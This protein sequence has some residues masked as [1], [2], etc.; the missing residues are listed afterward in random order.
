VRELDGVTN[1]TT[2]G[3][4]VTVACDPDAKTAVIGALEDAGIT[5]KDFRTEETSLEDL[6]LAYT[7]REVSA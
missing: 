5:V 4:T 7:E 6:F 2:D 1:A 3:G